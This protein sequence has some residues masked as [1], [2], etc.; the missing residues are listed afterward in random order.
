MLTNT[1]LELTAY[2]IR[3]HAI[4]G[5]YSAASGHPGGSLSISD[6][7]SV[8]YF[9]E[10]N[11]DPKDPKNPLR[12]RF[13]LSKGHCAPALYGAL[14]EKG[15]IPKEDIKTLRKSDSYLQGHPDMKA[16]PGVDMSTGSLGQ[17]ICTANGMALAAKLDKKDYRVYTILG[18]GEL[19]EGQ[20]WEAAMFA[21]HYK[22]DN[23]TAF[24]DFNGLQID[25]DITEVMNPTPIDKKFEAF[26]WNVLVIDAHNFDEI[27]DALKTAKE[28]KGK[29]TVIIAKSIKGKGVSYME[30]NAA[31]HGNAPKEED[32][33][34]A[35]KELDA[36]IEELEAKVNG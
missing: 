27:K 25:G 33:I 6:I 16:I 21:A 20:V 5:V 19:E 10:M 13:V 34:I 31:W 35:T 22:L 29:P 28:T 3:K 18:D 2:K 7:L 17:G 26:G 14:A 15:F 9:D 36:K 32:Y 11:V 4:D 1:Q 23:L 12:D 30:N 8:L 24:V